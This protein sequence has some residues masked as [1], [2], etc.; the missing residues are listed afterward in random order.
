MRG[1]WLTKKHLGPRR[2]MPISDLL[3]SPQ[4][5][6]KG[7]GHRCMDRNFLRG[8]ELPSMEKTS[9]AAHLETGWAEERQQGG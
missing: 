3:R 6:L 7:G 5:Y 4:F 8:N 9:G 2:E 1:S